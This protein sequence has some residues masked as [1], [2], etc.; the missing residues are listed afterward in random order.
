MFFIPKIHVIFLLYSYVHLDNLILYL[1]TIIEREKGKVLIVA[2]SSVCDMHGIW[3]NGSEY[4]IFVVQIDDF[5]N[6]NNHP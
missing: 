5:E 1:Y 4:N 6:R 2:L 3:W